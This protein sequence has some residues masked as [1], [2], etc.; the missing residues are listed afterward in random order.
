[1]Q[2][3]RAISEFTSF[4][5]NEASIETLEKRLNPNIDALFGAS[6]FPLL[7]KLNQPAVHAGGFSVAVLCFLHS[8]RRKISL[9]RIK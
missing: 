3:A 4:P 5:P 1:M 6:R 7:P 2:L 8:N 9:G